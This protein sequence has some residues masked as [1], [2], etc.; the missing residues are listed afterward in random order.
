MNQIEKHT[1]WKKIHFFG[2]VMALCFSSD[3][4]F[5]LAGQRKVHFV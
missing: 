5:L 2:S 1:Q 4:R 3:G